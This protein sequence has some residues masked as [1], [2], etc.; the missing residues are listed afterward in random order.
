MILSV[1]MAEVSVR[2]AAAAL[3]LTPRPDSVQG[4]RYA[5]AWLTL[6]LRTG[7]KPEV[8]PTG[9]LMLAAWDDDEALDKFLF[10]P[11]ARPYR[12]GWRT[13]M[14][15]VRSVGTLPGLPDLPRQE[16]PTGDQPVA[17]F[18]LG[19]LR[20]DKLL[21]FYLT[22][23][24]AEREART[25]PG[26]IA[27]VAL[28]RPPLAAGTF[29]IWRNSRE[30]RKYAL[31]SYPGGHKSAMAVDRERSF[32]H[33]MLFSRYLPYSAE[34]NWGGHN[35]LGH[36]DCAGNLDMVNRS[37]NVPETASRG[38]ADLGAMTFAPSELREG[39]S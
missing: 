31:G 1:H 28:F 38:D 9:V 24:A 21:P 33:E 25:H 15:P 22:A 12:N 39:I 29:S 36:L 7:L 26:F 18:T 3:R 17:A 8:V 20:A 32:W 11:R 35:P 30:M 34:G 14:A 2:K 6:P 4:L 16:R 10:H 5:S 19:R 13:R 23:A 27:G 37:W